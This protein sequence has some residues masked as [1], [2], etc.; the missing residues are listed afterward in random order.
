MFSLTYYCGGVVGEDIHSLLKAMHAQHGVPYQILD[1]SKDGAFDE[2][3]EKEV[4]DRDFKPQAKVLKRRTGR[5]ITDLRSRRA[6]HYFVS[7]PGTIALVQSEKI[8][9]YTLCD[10]NIRQFLDTAVTNGISHLNACC[11]A[12]QSTASCGVDRHETSIDKAH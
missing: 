3:R 12:Q 4:Y 8:Q 2:Q 11:R 6:R 10:D 1:L 9:W 5:S 7:R